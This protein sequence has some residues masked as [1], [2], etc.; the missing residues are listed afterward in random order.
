MK[1]KD[2]NKV[3][4]YCYI[5][6]R[7]SDGMKYHGL[8]WDNVAKKRTPNED[9]GIF[10]FTSRASLKKEFKKNK[11]NFKFKITYTFDDK[12]EAQEYERKFNEKIIKNNNWL[13]Q[14]AYPH[15]IQS[16]EGKERIR[17]SRLGK[18]LSKETIKK[19]VESGTGLKRSKKTKIKMSK[20]QRALNKILNKSTRKKISDTK[21]SQNLTAWNKN[22]KWTLKER[23]K[24]SKGMRGK[25][26]GSKNPFYGKK[27]SEETKKKMRL[28][29]LKNSKNPTKKMIEG[30]KKQS[31]KMRGR[32][33]QT[34]ESKKKISETHLGN[35][36]NIGRE[37]SKLTREKISLGNKG[38]KRSK[39]LK[40]QISESLKR[41]Y[42]SKTTS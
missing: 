28:A 31:Q 37:I 42:Q 1:T 40:K 6:T 34:K 10:Y 33:Y 13:N 14:S 24:I 15:L 7:L 18:K 16:R 38:K 25:M 32:H 35:K 12:K 30:R 4:P 22:R 20:A 41:Y 5:L 2:F 8:R 23:D 39:K 29:R 3:K 11:D 27:H 26:K 19:I 17:Q 9:F 36:Y 21:K